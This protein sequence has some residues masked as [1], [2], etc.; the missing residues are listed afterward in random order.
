MFLPVFSLVP[1]LLTLPGDF[2]ET[3]Q[4]LSGTERLATMQLV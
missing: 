4:F 3:K 2:S 1:L